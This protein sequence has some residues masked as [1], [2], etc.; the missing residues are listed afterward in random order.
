MYNAPSVV[1]PVGRCVFHALLLTIIGLV[2]A[3]V[4][5]LFLLGLVQR[6]DHS[7]GWTAVLACVLLWMAW[8]AVA[9]TSWLRSHQGTLEWDSNTVL[10]EG[11]AG[12]WLWS[13]PSSSE[14]VAL[15]QME[16][17]LDLQ[18]RILLR[19]RSVSTGQR[20]I[21]LERSRHPARWND[22]RR[23]LVSSRT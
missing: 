5:A 21:W 13:D 8:V 3:A 15:S 11:G 10:D 23:A 12:A 18:N 2:S 7:W 14:S 9:A 19:F 22:L 4:G 16:W 17:V 20:W 1:Y 6:L